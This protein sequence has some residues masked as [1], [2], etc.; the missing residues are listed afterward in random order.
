MSK[1]DNILNYQELDMARRK[2][3]IEVSSSKYIKNQEIAKAEFAKEKLSIQNIEQEVTQLV[4]KIKDRG[5]KDYISEAV[6]HFDELKDSLGSLDDIQEIAKLEMAIE[7]LMKQK[8]KV[9]E[10]ERKIVE[11]KS[12]GETLVN[13]YKSSTTKGKQMREAYNLNKTKYEAL[14]QEKIIEVDKIKKELEP[15]RAKISKELLE[16]YDEIAN[17]KKLPAFVPLIGND[18]CGGCGMQNSQKKIAML[19][20]EDTCVCDSCKRIIYKTEPSTNQPKKTS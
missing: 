11:Y 7:E 4:T 13:N 9:I 3:N 17:D 6:K 18:T 20:A 12:K 8:N 10:A 14:K 5:Y 16:K 19:I 2:I 1:L 15:L